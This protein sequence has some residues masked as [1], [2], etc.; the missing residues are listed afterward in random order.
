MG[1]VEAGA[2]TMARRVVGKAVSSIDVPKR[3]K[4]PEFRLSKSDVDVADHAKMVERAQQSGQP[5]TLQRNSGT[6]EANRNRYHAQKEIRKQRGGGPDEGYDY[7]EYP[8]ASSLQGGEGSHIEQVLSDVN[9]E[10]GQRLGR[11]YHE[12]N[13]LYGDP[14]DIIIEE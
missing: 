4:N 13:I 12:N 2:Q 9:Q 5:K 7:D 8:Y 10:A 11:F 14:Y 6:R 3:K 1:A